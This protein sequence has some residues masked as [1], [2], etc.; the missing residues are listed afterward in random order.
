MKIFNLFL[1]VLFIPSILSSQIVITGNVINDEKEPVNASVT[2]TIKGNPTIKTFTNTD[3]L[4]KYKLVYEG[5]ED[6]LVVNVSGMNIGK[7]SKIISNK[8][9]TLNFDIYN[10]PILLEEVVIKSPKV[11][12]TGDT[13][14]F[15]VS[16]YSDQNDKVLGDVLKKIPGMEVSSSGQI[17]YNGTSINKFY[18]EKMDMLQ[19]RYGIATN[20]INIDQISTIQVLENHQ[21]IK[22]LENKAYSDKPAINIKLKEESKGVLSINATLGGGYK[23]IMWDVELVSM[24]FGKKYQ[25]MNTYKTNNTGNNITSELSSFYE[26]NPAG[27]GSFLSVQSPS[28]PPFAKKRYLLGQTHAISINNLFKL[29]ENYQLNVNAIYY[30]D[31]STKEASSFSE[32]YLSSDSTLFIEEQSSLKSKTQNAEAEIRLNSNSKNYYLNNT[33]YLK[34]NWAYDD[35]LNKTRG[36]NIDDDIGQILNKPTYSI[37]NKFKIMKNIT[38]HIYNLDFNISYESKPHSLTVYPAIYEFYPDKELISY[39]QDILDNRLMSNIVISKI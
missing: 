17:S 13:I 26:G 33:L 39:K 23:P 16:A 14:D 27:T 21:P 8:S 31:K 20:N 7:H 2:L 22:M 11:T 19:G 24:L 29:S 37:S 15:R 30:N 5:K 35:G 18:I 4:G 28:T 25:N 10:K 32:I 38:K 9:Q 3:K 34:G 6:S 12:K 36:D 1:F